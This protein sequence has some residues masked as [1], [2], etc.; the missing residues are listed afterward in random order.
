MFFT[1]TNFLSIKFQ[2]RLKTKRI[3]QMLREESVLFFWIVKILSL[4][5]GNIS[6]LVE[7]SE[8]YDKYVTAVYTEKL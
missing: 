2:V 7:S 6:K 8:A 1:G 3:F 5:N 4:D